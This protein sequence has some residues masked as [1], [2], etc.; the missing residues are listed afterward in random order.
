MK[1]QVVVG[2]QRYRATVA[3]D[4]TDY[5]GFQIQPSGT[6][7]QG[8][9]ERALC[10]A[11][12]EAVRVAGAGRTDAGVHAQGQVISFETGW[13]HGVEALQRA[14]N[15]LLPADIIVRELGL[16]GERFHAR[17]SALQRVYRYWAYHAAAAQ[18]LLS[19]YAHGLGRPPDVEAMRRASAYLLGEHDYAAFGKVPSGANTVRAVQHAAWR[20]REPPPW[21]ESDVELWEFEIAA[22]A[23]LRGMVR[24]VVGTLL[25]VG[26]G[27]L[28]A[29]GFAEVLASR[30]PARS[31]VPAP[32]CGLTLWRVDY[33]GD[34]T[35]EERDAMRTLP[36]GR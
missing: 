27:E 32:A 16:A 5:G 10:S 31:G 17:F 13:R 14:M 11:T 15:A 26:G 12:Q 20:R 3:Y 2:T 34:D 24:R 29:G 30:D 33:G 22:N 21:A 9:L 28:S 6:T 7:I 18:P 25:L 35:G 1:P 4:G 23:F 19:R 36:P 8:E